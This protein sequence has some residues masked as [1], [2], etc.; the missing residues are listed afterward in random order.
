MKP[1]T[2][3]VRE[4]RNIIAATEPGAEPERMT[5]LVGQLGLVVAATHAIDTPEKAAVSLAAPELLAALSEIVRLWSG[6]KEKEHLSYIQL[7]AAKAAIFKAQGGRLG[8]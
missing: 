3:N 6:P 8:T 7:E 1:F 5:Y 4:I 2:L